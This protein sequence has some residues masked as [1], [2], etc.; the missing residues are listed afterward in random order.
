[1]TTSQQH[2]PRT[3]SGGPTVTTVSPHA[4]A[5]PAPNHN[6]RRL[7]VPDSATAAPPVSP[8]PVVVTHDCV[9]GHGRRLGLVGQVPIPV[10]LPQ[11][12]D[13]RAALTLELP[14]LLPVAL[15]AL[16]DAELWCGG[17]ETLAWRLVGRDRV[18]LHGLPEPRAACLIDWIRRAAVGDLV[19]DLGG[20]A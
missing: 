18:E 19:G 4:S 1:M 8:G 13:G 12:I 20:A 11:T 6:G 5:S 9:G 2:R 14:P 3:S 17:A 16:P 7:C 15:Y 10:L